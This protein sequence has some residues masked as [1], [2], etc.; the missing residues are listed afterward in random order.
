MTCSQCRGIEL[1]F[2]DGTARREL[3][4]YR[5]RGPT[6]TTRRLLDMMSDMGIGGRTFLDIGGG[7]GSIQHEL[8]RASARGGTHVDASPA[9]LKASREEARTR[10]YEEHVTYVEGDFLDVSRD[11]P[12]A[13]FVTLD[14]VICCY[15]NM[16]GLVD[17]S[18]PKA[19]VAYG[20]VYPRDTWLVR[21]IFR[22]I[23]LIQRVR[24]HPFRA[25]V[26]RT[27]EVEERVA[28]H[29]LHKRSIRR[30]PI[31]QVVLF[32]RRTSADSEARES[33]DSDSR[34]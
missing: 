14:R 4:R 10:G 32:D 24:R 8:M 15:P 5:R 7:V 23:N 12:T 6:G 26:H 13:D 11:V 1:Q 18:A 27:A 21:W 25:F 29:G 20:V 3:R 30:T 31:W 17:A 9:Y 2:D 22:A 16:R 34:R 33:T 19:R 28:R